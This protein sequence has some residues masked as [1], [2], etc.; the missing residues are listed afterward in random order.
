MSIESG[1]DDETVGSKMGVSGRQARTYIS[2]AKIR[3]VEALRKAMGVKGAIRFILL[4]HMQ[5]QMHSQP[6]KRAKTQ[7][8]G[9]KC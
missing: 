2:R 1:L 9:K 8:P 5:R 6:R 7:K 3:K 4:W